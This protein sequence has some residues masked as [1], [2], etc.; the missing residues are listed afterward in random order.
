MYMPASVKVSY[1]AD[2]T[3]TS[4]GTFTAGA[5]D[6]AGKIMEGKDLGEEDKARLKGAAG[7]A[8]EGASLQMLD[9][10]GGLREAIE[11][12]RGV[13]F[14]D[15]M[16]LAFKGID[17]RTFTYDFKMLPRS[18]AEADEVANIV[19]AFKHNM[20]PEFLGD[21]RKGRRLRVPN[22]FDIQYMYVNQENKYLHKIST[23]YLESMDVEYGGS[24][25]AGY[26]TFDGN[27]DGA[28]PVETS[29][30]L[31]FKEIELITRERVQEGF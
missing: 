31:S 12:K 9:A 1:G 27:K 29:I 21:D 16:E 10:V 28:P 14:A 8:A 5:V 23:C 3:D 24:G 4:V 6:V 18:K 7:E 11:M 19:Y 25:E 13:V 30:S 20:M 15:R 17:K 2:Y 26:K 22:T